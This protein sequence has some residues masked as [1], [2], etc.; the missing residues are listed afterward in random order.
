VQAQISDHAAENRRNKTGPPDRFAVAGDYN[1][2]ASEKEL[3][4]LRLV[5]APEIDLPHHWKYDPGRMLAIVVNAD[6]RFLYFRRSRLRLPVLQIPGEVWEKAAR[7]LN[8]DAVSF[9]EL[10]AGDQVRQ[11]YFVNLAGS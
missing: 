9:F 3:C 8:T 4:P 10:V 11:I 7:D 1:G 5:L 2:R 6:R